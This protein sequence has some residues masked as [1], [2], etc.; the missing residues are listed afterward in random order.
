MFETVCD[1]TVNKIILHWLAYNRHTVP[2]NMEKKGSL[3]VLYG[4][5]SQAL[6]INYDPDSPRSFKSICLKCN[7]TRFLD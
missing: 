6:A 5:Y 3:S 2:T 4:Y 1:A 7:T